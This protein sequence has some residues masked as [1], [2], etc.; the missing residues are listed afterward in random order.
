M[1]KVVLMVAAPAFAWFAMSIWYAPH[2]AEAQSGTRRVQQAHYDT[3]WNWL[4]SAGYT[5]WNGV[6]GRPA[7]F[8]EG[9]SPHGA[10]VKVYLSPHTAASANGLPAGSVIVKENYSPDRKLMAITVMHRSPG[11]D[12]QHG[13]WYYAKYMPN[14]RIATTPPEKKSMPIAGRFSSCIDCHSAAGGNDFAYFND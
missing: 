1:S 12:P 8:Q 13:D 5:H 14:G 11:F 3:L 7:E 9:Q 2:Q 6:G 4:K 10:L